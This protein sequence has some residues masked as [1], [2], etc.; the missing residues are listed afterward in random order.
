MSHQRYTLYFGQ[1][2]STRVSPS[3]SSVIY[4]IIISP[5]EAYFNSL[6]PTVSICLI[7]NLVL[8]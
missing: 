3:T 8:G 4:Q 5:L 6:L 1:L 7:S 2:K